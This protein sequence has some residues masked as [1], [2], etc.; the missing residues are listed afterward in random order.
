[1]KKVVIT[2]GGISERIDNV[3]KITNSS[4]GKL[5]MIIAN[6][7]LSGMDDVEIYY[8]CSKNSFRPDDDRVKVI[9][10]D[11]VSKVIDEYYDGDYS[12]GFY[13]IN[14]VGH[15]SIMMSDTPQKLKDIGMVG[16]NLPE[17]MYSKKLV[18]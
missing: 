1:M 12:K 18:R 7:F 11:E 10:V 13:V 5:G 4:S 16:R 9:E 2:A 6:R 3:R 15:G 8:I 14:L 17:D